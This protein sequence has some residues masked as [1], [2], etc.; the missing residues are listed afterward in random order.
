MG[1]TP[2]A[3]LVIS[4][5]ANEDIFSTLPKKVIELGTQEVHCQ[6][7]DLIDHLFESF[8]VEPVWN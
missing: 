7:S 8:C 6:D 4:D 3:L 1:I 2:S 5:M